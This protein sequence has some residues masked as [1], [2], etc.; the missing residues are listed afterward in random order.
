MLDSGVFAVPNEH[1]EDLLKHGKLVLQE[2]DGDGTKYYMYR[3]CGMRNM[4][5]LSCRD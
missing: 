3:M 4:T 1:N 2:C 5:P